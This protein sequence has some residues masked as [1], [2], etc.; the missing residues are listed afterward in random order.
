MA[1]G[2][3]FFDAPQIING[4]ALTRSMVSM[5]LNRDHVQFLSVFTIVFPN[6]SRLECVSRLLNK[7]HTFSFSSLAGIFD[8]GW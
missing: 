4:D 3:A 7:F 5:V 2:G 6:S 1:F 8:A